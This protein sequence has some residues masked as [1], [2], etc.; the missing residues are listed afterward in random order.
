MDGMAVHVAEKMENL[1]QLLTTKLL[2]P[3]FPPS[4]D[5]QVPILIPT[6]G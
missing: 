1:E 2:N 5:L 4:T 3:I 6:R